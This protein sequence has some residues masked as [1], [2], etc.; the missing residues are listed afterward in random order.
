M[1][2]DAG[3]R[4]TSLHIYPVKSCGGI[5]LGRIAGGPHG[6]ALRPPVGV[7]GRARD[8]RRPAR[9]AR[10]GR[11]GAHDVPDRDGDR[12][13]RPHPDA[14]RT[15]RRCECRPTASPARGAGAGLGE[16]TPVAS[17]RARTAS[18]LG[19]PKCCRAS[20]RDAI[21]WSA[22][23]TRPAARSKIGD[24]EVAY[25]D[26]Y[27]FLVLSEESLADLNA[28]DAGAAADEPLP[29]QYRH[30]RRRR[31]TSR[32]R[33]TASGSERSSSPARRC[34]SAVR[35]PTTDQRTAERG[36]EP[37]RTLATYRKQ[38]DGVVFGR[39]FNHA[40]TGYV[41]VG[42]RVEPPASM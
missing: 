6:P 37:L 39:N 29:A 25:G 3:L 24:G 40:G 42:D 4:V 34:A 23:P 5:A 36:K 18:A 7:R 38:P 17:I 28:A 19:R 31:R 10:P 9:F 8:V 26:A 35:F 30:R 16:R 14:R 13:R 15:C 21:G 12:R 11:A 2:P 22:W 1:T 20:A 32:T 33:W 27:P 41:R